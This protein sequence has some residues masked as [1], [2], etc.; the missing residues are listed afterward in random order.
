MS[1]RFMP[2]LSLASGDKMPLMSLRVPEEVDPELTKEIIKHSVL[3]GGYRHLEFESVSKKA[4][5]IK[6]ALVE[7]Q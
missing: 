7:I 3:E 5:K 2:S 6:E 1:F 4:M